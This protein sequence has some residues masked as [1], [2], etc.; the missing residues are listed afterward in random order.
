MDY[1]S[2]HAF[3]SK[4][5]PG[6]TFKVRDLSE[7]ERAKLRL[8]LAEC[9]RRARQIESDRA[10]FY[11]GLAE[12]LGKP[13]EE[14]RV[15]D[16][17][18]AQREQLDD[19]STELEVITQTELNPAYLA[20]GLVAVEGLTING[21][22]LISAE[23]LVKDGPPALIGEVLAEIFKRATLTPEERQNLG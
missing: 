10:E 14:I 6:V 19:W 4:T 15:K 9:L 2:I 3:E 23:T 13:V 7:F 8:K 20:A 16:I 17:S 11:E 21:S 5:C 12:E 22:A 1:T 18:R